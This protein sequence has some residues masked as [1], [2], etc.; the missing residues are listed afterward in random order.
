MS[1]PTNS[2]LLEKARLALARVL[3]GATFVS[4]NG[5]QF[6][7]SSVPELRALIRELEV[8]VAEENG[9]DGRGAWE[10]AFNE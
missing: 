3:D 8:A 9:T 6:H 10:A 4:V 5:Q 7:Y 1:A 2:E